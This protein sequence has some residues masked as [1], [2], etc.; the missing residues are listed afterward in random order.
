MESQRKKTCDVHSFDWKLTPASAILTL[1][2]WVLTGFAD[3][4]ILAWVFKNFQL[5][6]SKSPAFQKMNLQSFPSLWIC[7]CPNSHVFRSFSKILAGI[8]TEQE[9]WRNDED[10][11]PD[12]IGMQ[13]CI[14]RRERTYPALAAKES[15]T[16]YINR[17][18]ECPSASYIF[19]WFMLEFISNQQWQNVQPRGL[20]IQT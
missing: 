2:F 10:V 16:F 20:K 7:P 6:F 3:L 18:F 4:P 8:W 5:A 9:Q 11:I 14:F 12:G 19:I 15:C 1:P 17:C 13:S